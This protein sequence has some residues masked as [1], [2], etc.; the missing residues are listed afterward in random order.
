MG[1][2]VT[3]LSIQKTT[4]MDIHLGYVYDRLYLDLYPGGTESNYLCNVI[5]SI[6]SVTNL[7]SVKIK[8][9]V[10]PFYSI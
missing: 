3:F 4:D 9:G 8:N 1:K 2:E 6:L 5:G 10:F 7:I